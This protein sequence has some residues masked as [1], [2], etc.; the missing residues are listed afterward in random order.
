MQT[1]PF[2]LIFHNCTYKTDKQ[3]QLWRSPT[4]TM[5]KIALATALVL[6]AASSAYAADRDDADTGGGFRVGPLGQSMSSGVN[7]VYHRSLRAGTPARGA[8]A[9]AP[10]RQSY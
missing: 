2:S 4:M 3:T 9:R 5:S 8:Y 1:K 10:E 6:V 7:P